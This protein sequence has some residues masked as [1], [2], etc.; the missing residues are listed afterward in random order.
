MG[1]QGHGPTHHLSFLVAENQG[2]GDP[3]VRTAAL[4]RASDRIKCLVTSITASPVDPIHEA[5]L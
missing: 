5:T 3:W 2:D 1:S 4:G